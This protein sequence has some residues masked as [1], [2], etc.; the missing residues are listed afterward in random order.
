MDHSGAARRWRRPSQRAQGAGW[1]RRQARARSLG[2]GW[3]RTAGLDS[4]EAT[5]NHALWH[6]DFHHGSLRVVDADG[7]WHTPKLLGFIDDR[8][9]VVP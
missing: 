9:R 1:N 7:T 3:D 2:L 4:F 8:S 5:H 6:Y